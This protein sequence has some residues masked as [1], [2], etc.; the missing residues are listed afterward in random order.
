MPQ[1]IPLNVVNTS[2]PAT[3]TITYYTLKQSVG[4]L[5][6]DKLIHH[7]TYLSN[8]SVKISHIDKYLRLNP[9]KTASI[10]SPRQTNPKQ[11]LRQCRPL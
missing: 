11:K 10:K 2:E 8:G 6:L 7:F 9:G 4:F 5:K 3:K 1:Q